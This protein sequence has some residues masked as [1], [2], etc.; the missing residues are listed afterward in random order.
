MSQQRQPWEQKSTAAGRF[1]LLPPHLSQV[2]ISG[3][4]SVPLLRLLSLS[5]FALSISLFTAALFFVYRSCELAVG[6]LCGDVQID[7]SEWKPELAALL[8]V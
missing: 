2:A 1:G 4:D 7:M 3:H 6:F 8:D 5:V